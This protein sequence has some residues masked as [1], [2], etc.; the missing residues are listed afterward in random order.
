MIPEQ[1]TVEFEWM[2][3]LGPTTEVLDH[4]FASSDR[5]TDDLLTM[6]HMLGLLRD[7]VR[8][9]PPSEPRDARFTD[10]SGRSYKLILPHPALLS[11]GGEMSAVGFFGQAR[12]DTDHEPINLLEESLIATMTEQPGLITYFNLFTPSVGWGNLVLFADV[13]AKNGWGSDPRHDEA[14][15]RS[16]LHYHSIR[17]HNGRLRG[18]LVGNENISL[19]KT[20]YF[21]FDGPQPWQAERHYVSS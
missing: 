17:L 2:L 7:Q 19:I 8:Q 16:P 18:G 9:R 1:A 5:S 6:N 20:R 10:S 21:D 13:V 4:G 12:V 11:V 3:L 14:V 15:A